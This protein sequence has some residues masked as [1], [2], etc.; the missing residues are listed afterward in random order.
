MMDKDELLKEH[1]S[2]AEVIAL[3][4]FNIPKADFKEATSEAYLAL[5]RAVESFDPS[6]GEFIPYAA[7]S[8]RNALNTLYAKHLRMAK[9]FPKSLDSAPAW[10]NAAGFGSSS[11]KSLSGRFADSR[12]DV[13][14]QVALQETNSI[15]SEVMDTLS[16]RER[17]VLEKIRLG[18]S[19]SEIGNKMGIS[20]QAV[21]KISAPALVKLRS[22]LEA[23]GFRGIDSYGLLK[24][25][26]AGTKRKSV[27][28]F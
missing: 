13:R 6:K 2:L 11:S 9:M 4:Y 16:P 3:E 15:M 1:L 24:A 27:D 7:R 17:S 14:R 21:H 25:S 19:L 8:I 12:Q 20:K 26:S 22:H 28:E 23:M 18:F 10:K 5:N